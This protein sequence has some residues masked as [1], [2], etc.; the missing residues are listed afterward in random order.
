[1]KESQLAK[2]LKDISDHITES[3]LIE[4]IYQLTKNYGKGKVNQGRY[5]TNVNFRLDYKN[6]QINLD[7][8]KSEMGGGDLEVF[9]NEKLV[10]SLDRNL[11]Q[12]KNT[13]SANGWGITTY[14]KGN[15]EN[16]LEKVQNELEKEKKEQNKK[17][18]MKKE[19]VPE[20]IIKEM[21]SRYDL[22]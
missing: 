16:E 18:L 9:Y 14:F 13:P 12:K 4:T 11:D 5:N 22:N 8:G 17:I 2:K 20:E 3:N 21:K 7:D 6:F 1:M 19:E 10:L 15:W